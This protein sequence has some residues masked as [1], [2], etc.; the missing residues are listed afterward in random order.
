[1]N[2][3]YVKVADF[4]EWLEHHRDIVDRYIQA[5]L[6]NGHFQPIIEH[7][8][9][10]WYVHPCIIF[11]MKR[12]SDPGVLLDELMSLYHKSPVLVSE[13]AYWIK[14]A[15]ASTQRQRELEERLEQCLHDYNELQKRYIKVTETV[16]KLFED[17]TDKVVVN[18]KYRGDELIVTLIKTKADINI[19]HDEFYREFIC[20]D[21]NETGKEISDRLCQYGRQV[22]D[23]YIISDVNALLEALEE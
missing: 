8:D 23:V 9:D 11:E 3:D 19:P 15:F 16:C 2:W 12:Q 21:M 10:G 14:E 7:H 5:S 22:G 18:G 6:T 17:P 1:M 13:K 4:D 20:H